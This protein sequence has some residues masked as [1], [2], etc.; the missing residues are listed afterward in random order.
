MAK[1]PRAAE[2]CENLRYYKFLKSH[3]ETVW[4][5]YPFLNTDIPLCP[6][7]PIAFVFVFECLLPILTHPFF[8]Y[9]ELLDSGF[10]Y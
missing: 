4:A 7:P 8:Y 6:R 9:T 1:F 5:R 10:R 3:I 2:I